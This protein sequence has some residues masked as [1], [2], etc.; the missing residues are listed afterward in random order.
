MMVNKE[1][2]LSTGKKCTIGGEWE[3]EG[4]ICTIVYISKGEMMPTYCGKNVK[5][6]LVKKG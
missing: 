5:W 6:F 1:I 2:S 4:K 3:N